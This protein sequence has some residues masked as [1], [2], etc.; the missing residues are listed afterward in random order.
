MPSLG[1]RPKDFSTVST[2]GNIYTMN[3]WTIH[4]LSL[5]SKTTTIYGSEAFNPAY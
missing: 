1:A 4:R 5:A 3:K 2:L